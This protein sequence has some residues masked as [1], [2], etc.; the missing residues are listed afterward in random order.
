MTE[1]LI[2]CWQ[3]HP[4]LQ[5][6]LAPLRLATVLIVNSKS[7]VEEYR[8]VFALVITDKESACRI[9]R[10]LC[11][12]M[13]NRY[14]VD[15]FLSHHFEFLHTLVLACPPFIRVGMPVDDP[16]CGIIR[17][18]ATACQ[19]QLCSRSTSEEI[20]EIPNISQG[21]VTMK[22]VHRIL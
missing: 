4:R 13:C 19:R 11:R 1:L 3:Y 18:I 9:A 6:R 7:P 20:W 15:E 2:Y 17:S 21:L 5:T 10:L 16:S 14:L 12:D 22:Y 8:K